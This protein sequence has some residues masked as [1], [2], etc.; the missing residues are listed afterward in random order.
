MRGREG[1][2][3]ILSITRILSVLKD[4]EIVQTIKPVVL[5]LLRSHD[6]DIDVDHLM[7]PVSSPARGYDPLRMLPVQFHN[8][9]LLDISA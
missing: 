8:N 3:V 1:G 7:Y 2:P 4:R 9:I 6:I 5:N